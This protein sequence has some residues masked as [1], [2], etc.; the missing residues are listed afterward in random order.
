M[1]MKK[2]DIWFMPECSANF[3]VEANSIEEAR[4]VAEEVLCNMESKE[5]MR[6]IGDAVDFM[7]VKI[8]YIDEIEEE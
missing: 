4:E 8:D 1:N 2:Y 7:G 3:V 6:R 5:L